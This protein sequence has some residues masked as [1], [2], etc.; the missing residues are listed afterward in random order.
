MKKIALFKASVGIFFF[1]YLLVILESS[2]QNEY[3]EYFLIRKE[4]HFFLKLYL[5]Y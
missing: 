2:K 1:M 5:L 4:F 3:N